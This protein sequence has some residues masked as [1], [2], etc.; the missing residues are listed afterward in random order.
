MYGRST[1]VKAF[2][3]GTARGIPGPD[4]DNSRL[5]NQPLLLYPCAALLSQFQ[6]NNLP[7]HGESNVKSVN[8]LETPTIFTGF[9]YK[10]VFFFLRK[11]SLEP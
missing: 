7:I 2:V 10:A 6:A 4:P 5:K 11:R 8:N 3:S 1:P 9:T